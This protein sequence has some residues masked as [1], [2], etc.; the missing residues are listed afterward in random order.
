MSVTI[1]H[2][3]NLERVCTTAQ[4][5]ALERIRTGGAVSLS[6]VNLLKEA[7][8]AWEKHVD[9]VLEARKS[10]SFVSSPPH[11][12]E[13]TNETLAAF[14]FGSMDADVLL[15]TLNL[16]LHLTQLDPILGEETGMDGSHLI[17]TLLMKRIF[18]KIDSLDTY[19][20]TSEEDEDAVNDLRDVAFS[21]ASC[22]REVFP[23]RNTPLTK[24]ERMRRLPLLFSV[25]PA[26][27]VNEDATRASILVHQIPTRQSA[28]EDVGMFRLC[29]QM[30]ASSENTFF[31]ALTP[32]YL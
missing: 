2:L 11:L 8:E 6:C 3:I 24:E 19:S 1:R 4:Q 26:L 15:R 5:L 21:I 16:H 29:Q 27:N 14:A 28:Q 10:R 22:F 30:I 18:P 23:I 32:N 13:D 12:T 25:E 31:K 17:L 20:Y 7:V 9:C